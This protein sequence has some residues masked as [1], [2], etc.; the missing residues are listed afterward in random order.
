VKIAH[1]ADL[2]LGFRQFDRQNRNGANQREAD[3]ADAFRRAVTD[4]VVAQP[5]VVLL[6]GDLFHSVRPTNYA[7]CTFFA[8]L[9]RLRS[10]LPNAHLVAIAGDHD[11]PRSSETGYI[12]PLYRALGLDIALTEPVVFP[13][14]H[15]WAVTAVPKWAVPKLPELR[16]QAGARNVLLVH[17][18]ARHV[19][20]RQMDPEQL[21][22]WDYIALGHYHSCHQVG[23][24]AWYAGSLEY[25]STNIWSESR[26]PSIWG[27]L[28]EDRGQGLAKGWLRVEFGDGVDPTVQQRR[29]ATRRVVDLEPIDATGLSPS[30]IDA[31][32]A[33]RSLDI[34]GAWVRL[35]VTNATRSTQHALNHAAIRELKTRAL[36]FHLDCRRPQAE[37]VQ[38]RS[39]RQLV[40][41]AAG[42]GGAVPED[43]LLCARCSGREDPWAGA[44][45]TEGVE[46][47]L[48][49]LAGELRLAIA[50]GTML[51]DPYL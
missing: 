39:L 40:D 41:C 20:G 19:P 4:V 43:E 17:G 38:A 50:S 48:E 21:T 37:T 7:I 27:E 23:P 35:V 12:L 34:D 31:A 6:A 5:D 22:A 2:H 51:P 26:E 36:N 32:I 15:G 33:A 28:A 8:E 47:S 42:C 30:E 3:V 1:L 13:L 49:Q 29:V 10:G 9:Q 44:D 24:R 18:E 46:P 45:Y 16:P 14:G 11:S 25:V